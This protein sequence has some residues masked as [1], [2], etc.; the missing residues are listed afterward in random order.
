MRASWF[1]RESDD[2]DDGIGI[3]MLSTRG[4]LTA[5]PDGV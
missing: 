1:A 3:T 2:D 4:G 5:A